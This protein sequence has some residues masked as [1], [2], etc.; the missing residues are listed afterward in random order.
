MSLTGEDFHDASLTGPRASYSIPNGGVFSGYAAV[1]IDAPPE[2]VY[3]A[4]VEVGDYKQWNTFVDDVTITKN[5]NPHQKRDGSTNS[6]RMAGGTCMIF[7]SRLVKEPEYRSKSREVATLVEALKLAKDNHSMPCIT[8]IRWSLDNA[9][10]ST[11]G[12]LLKAERTNEIEEVGDGTTLY[13]T[14]ETF[15]GPIAYIIRMKFEAAL[16]DRMSDWCQDLK[17]WCEK[18]N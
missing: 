4:L 2:A 17:R 11:P 7:H 15:S 3:K 14:W 9:A 18:T 5:P 8:R 10:I 6:N 13:R 12:F 1:K 16:K